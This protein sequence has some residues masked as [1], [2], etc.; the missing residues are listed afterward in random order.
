[1]ETLLSDQELENVF[2]MCDAKNKGFITVTD[3]QAWISDPDTLA[4]ILISLNMGPNE[5]VSLHEFVSRN[6]ELG[7]K[8]QIKLAN[9]KP[10]P[11]V[12]P[13]RPGV[14]FA[15]F[16]DELFRKKVFCKV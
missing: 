5:E 11:P 12:P 1:M 15:T 13:L 9:V 6:R 3:L 16:Y 8:R 10:T 7:A 4:E 2:R 14:N